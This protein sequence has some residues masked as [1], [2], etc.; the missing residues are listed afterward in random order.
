MS[1][2]VVATAITSASVLLG[3]IS[4]LI[5][6]AFVVRRTGSTTGLRDVAI[7]VRAFRI[8]FSFRDK[9]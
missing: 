7:A 6:C 8:A 4:F 2:F 3:F 5:F 9:P 1:A